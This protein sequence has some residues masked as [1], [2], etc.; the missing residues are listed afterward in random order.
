MEPNQNN[1]N[2]KQI[3]FSQ[4]INEYS[5]TIPIIQRD[6]AQ[7]RESQNE[8][9]EAFLNELLIS[10]IND[11][12]LN[13]DFVYGSI[14][15]G[16]LI[17]LDGQQRLTTLFLLHWYL[18]L[19]ENKFDNFEK[20]ILDSYGNCKF[21][22][23]TRTSSRDFCNCLVK[24]KLDLMSFFENESSKYSLSDF[25]KNSSWFYLSWNNDP[26]I[27]SMLNMLDAIHDKFGEENAFYTKL[28]DND[29][30]LITFQFLRLDDYKLSDDIYIKMNARGKLLTNFE[31]FKAWL[32][33]QVKAK[34]FNITTNNWEVK[35]D[36]EWTDIFWDNKDKDSFE[37]DKQF[38]SFFKLIFL[39]YF[40]EKEKEKIETRRFVPV[41]VVHPIITELINQNDIRYSTLEIIMTESN[42]NN[43]FYLFTYFENN[44]FNTIHKYV[45][46]L[47]GNED[48]IQKRLIGTLNSNMNLWDRTYLY[49]FI[50]FIL[51][52][53]KKLINYD[54]DELNQL[55]HWLRVTKNL[56]FNTIIDS[57]EDFSNAI[58]QIK[59][60][61]E[62]VKNNNFDIYNVLSNEIVEISFLSSNQ[63]EEEKIKSKLITT[64]TVNDWESEF[65][66]YENHH[67]FAG[68]IGF[69]IEFSKR[70]EGNFDFGLFQNYSKKASSIF[71]EIIVKSTDF[72]FERALLSK[73]SYLMKL[74]YHNDNFCKPDASRLRTREENWRR[75]FRNKQEILKN[76]FD[77][78]KTDDITSELKRI[79][80]EYISNV[81]SGIIQ[82]DWRYY[83]V[84]SKEL[85]L[86]CRDRL[87]RMSSDNNIMLLSKTQMNSYHTEL[88]TYSFY[89]N[90][91]NGK[92][93]D[94][95][96]F[97][98]IYYEE[99]KSYDLPYIFLSSYSTNTAYTLKIYLIS[100]Q[101]KMKFML[102]NNDPGIETNL[103]KI[104]T[105]AGFSLDGS[106]YVKFTPIH[107]ELGLVSILK[108]L[109]DEL[110]K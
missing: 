52:K 60:L 46:I 45:K 82:K 38:F 37:I 104:I 53:G 70:P 40:V 75:V 35:L 95:E 88:Y 97:T 49:S 42:L 76:L 83:F 92:F 11:E 91:I 89:L 110:K 7:G 3:S 94:Y 81:D 23:E 63:L 62:K 85:I 108:K 25:I 109:C 61:F 50:I 33:K 54:K 28:T 8:V 34:G 77:D 72:I 43:I 18:A 105:N 59:T 80:N 27:R 86:Y 14:E 74:G 47:F 106:E 44:G 12:P 78:I 1:I 96:P 31:T 32:Q 56:I 21:T 73:G 5:V 103:I 39:F 19:K 9:R 26:T 36:V 98:N 24:K 30:P 107:D 20:V 93:D 22:Y 67:Y 17:P 99:S 58:P 2:G 4:L 6:Y 100:N 90:F 79:I 66:K 69:L 87:I 71:S 51:G 13:L 101:F 15:N 48:Y 10:L 68:Q 64:N 16:S 55:F 57:A 29:R 84:K 65:I 102:G 41:G